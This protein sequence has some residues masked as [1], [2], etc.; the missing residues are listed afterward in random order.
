[1]SENQTKPRNWQRILLVA[2]LA[3]NLCIIGA[4]A[5]IAL[6]GGPKDRV[7]RFDLTVGPLTRAMDSDRRDAIR[8]DLRESGAFRAE[9]RAGMRRDVA[10]LLVTL[11]QDGFDEAAFRDVLMRQRDRMQS[12]QAAVI[13]AVAAQVTDMSPQERAAFADALEEQFRRTPP[14]QRDG[15]S[16]G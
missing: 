9:D 14:P 10:A 2:S 11:R 8:E 16:G 13:E 12:G 5:G 15:P 1:M 6:G 3:L 7:Q 4:V